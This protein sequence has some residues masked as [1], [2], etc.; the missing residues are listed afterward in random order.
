MTPALPRWWREPWWARVTLAAILVAFAILTTWNLARGGDFSFYEASA[1]SM[2]QSWQALLF[3][4]FDPAAT[5]TLDKLSGFAVPQALSVHLFGMSTSAL[6]LPQVIEGL[7]TVFA[8]SLIGLRWRGRAVGLVAAGAA[9]STPIFVSM[10][11]HPMED[12]LLTMSLTVAVLW[13]Q[14]AVLTMRWWPLL[15][16]GLFIGVGF[17]AKMMQAWF[18]VPAL[19]LGTVI[20]VGGSWPRRLG[21]AFALLAS[22]VLA[23]LSWM[24]MMQLV[25]ANSRPFV[26]GSTDN[27][28]FAMVFGYNGIDRLFPNAIEGA[29]RSGGGAGSASEASA[30][31]TKLIDP[32]YLGQ[33]GWLYP[34]AAVGVALGVWS[35]VQMWRRRHTPPDHPRGAASRSATDSATFLVLMVWLATGVVILS[36]ARMPHTAYLSA[37]GVQLAL[38]AAVAVD[39][40]VRLREAPGLARRLVLPALALVQLSWCLVLAVVTSMPRPL[41]I[42]MIVVTAG[43]CVVVLLGAFR[44]PWRRRLGR[45]IAIAGAVGVLAGPALY[46]V[47]VLD[48]ARDGSGGDAYVGVKHEDPRVAG[49]AAFRPSPPQ[50][51]G[52]APGIT[53]AVVELVAASRAAGGG[54]E[55]APLFLT[56]AWSIAAPV[57]DATGDE[58]LTDGGYSGQAVVFTAAEVT[59]KIRAGLH[60]IVVKD[61]APKDDPVASAVHAGSCRTVRSWPAPAEV[62][63]AGKSSSGGG[64]GG[65]TLYSCS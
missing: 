64:A 24:L 21:R 44:A 28:V 43:M 2:S 13:W 23:S 8:C 34:A 31:A 29:V 61:H 58:V 49:N 36:A 52:G 32:M 42:A 19:L 47:Q 26:D 62:G 10:F 22:T 51:W 33:I 16:A 50:L 55:G 38:L 18:V 12:G 37:I 35:G 45:T 41:W 57:I 54:H 63:H 25:P 30:G 48:A 39:E 60:L 20:A 17:Q 65:F 6:A 1:R 14:R 46:A 3:G 9:A 7:V 53:P 59:A 27:D 15:C 5:V 11:G 4:A 56:D 40:A